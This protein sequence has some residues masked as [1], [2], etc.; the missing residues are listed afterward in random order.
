MATRNEAIDWL[1]GVAMVLMALDHTRALLGSAV[2]LDTAAPALF[3]TRWVTHFCAPVFVLLAGTAAYL[4]GRRLASTRALSRYLLTRGLWLVLV[5]VTVV[6]FAWIVEIGPQHLFLQVIWTIGASMIVL[7][8]LVWLPRWAIA[9]FALILI[10]GHDLFDAVK[11]EQL[12][13]ARWLWVLLHES[14]TLEPFA[15]ARWL[16][17]YPLVP[18]IAVIAAGYALGPWALL[19]RDERRARFARLGAALI[20]GFILVRASNLYGDPQPWTAEHGLL[21]AVLGFLNC[22][23]YPPSLLF[24]A[25]T[26]GPACCALAW[27][28]RPLGPWAERLSLYGRVPL[29]YYVLHLYLIHTVA[30]VLAWHELGGDAVMQRFPNGAPVYSLP[31]VYAFWATFV[32][33]LYPACHWFAGVKRRSHAAWMSYL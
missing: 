9:A 10:G 27:M 30:I 23:K 2:E 8:G 3:F 15:G 11:A 4:H 22:A 31:A 25:M 19:P 18:W 12:G 32:L 21:R 6:R 28:D 29:F 5:E 13:S 26:L 20:V 16:I 24:L 17:I 33:V 14:G 7:A 1:R